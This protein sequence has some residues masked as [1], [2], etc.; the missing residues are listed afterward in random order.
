VLEVRLPFPVGEASAASPDGRLRAAAEPAADGRA[1]VVLGD[2]G[3]Y[4]IVVLRPAGE[5]R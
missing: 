3:V 4:G 5:P 1:R 2:A